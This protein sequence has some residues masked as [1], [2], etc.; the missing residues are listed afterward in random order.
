M[1]KIQLVTRW[2]KDLGFNF[3]CLKQLEGWC[4][5]I[6]PAKVK[7]PTLLQRNEWKIQGS[8]SHKHKKKC[9]FFLASFLN[10]LQY[11]RQV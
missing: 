4:R 6:I 1:N 3:L 9:A 5:G 7:A 8:L 2:K 11:I 10:S